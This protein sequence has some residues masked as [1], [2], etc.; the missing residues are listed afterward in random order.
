MI[1]IELSVPLT[2]TISQCK[3]QYDTG[4]RKRKWKEEVMRQQKI[5]YSGQNDEEL[6]ESSTCLLFG[7]TLPSCG[8]STEGSVLIV[9][10]L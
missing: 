10:F 5:R 9:H 3:S 4:E 1:W 2:S 6:S 7:A 8:H